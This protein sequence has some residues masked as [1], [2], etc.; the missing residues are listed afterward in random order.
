MRRFGAPG[1]WRAFIRRNRD[2]RHQH[3]TACGHCCLRIRGRARQRRIQ[4]AHRWGGPP[5]GDPVLDSIRT[6]WVHHFLHSSR[7]RGSLVWALIHA[8][9]APRP[10]LPPDI[11]SFLDP[12]VCKPSLL[13]VLLMVFFGAPEI[14]CRHYFGNNGPP[15]TSGARER[16]LRRL[17]VSLLLGCVIENPGAILSSHVGTLPVRSCWIMVLPKHLE[18]FLIGN[19]G[20]IKLNLNNFRM[21]CFI[22]AD[23]LVG[24]ILQRSPHIADR[25]GSDTFHL[26]KRGFHAPKTARSECRFFHSSSVAAQ[27]G[28]RPTAWTGYQPMPV[29]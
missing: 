12:A 5:S 13:E 29:S 4:L 22:G 7:S 15:K 23:V 9:L 18:K 14:G 28:P 20:G 8:A 2:G 24:W 10:F 16:P 11:F 1:A 19:L 21:T 17:G 3:S 27:H 26:P 25:G 6:G